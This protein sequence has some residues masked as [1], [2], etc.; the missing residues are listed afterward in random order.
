MPGLRLT[1][2][3]AERLFGLSAATCE[4][5]IRTLMASGFLMRSHTG[6]FSLAVS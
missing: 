4:A 6:V 2:S 5:V 1:A 3:Q